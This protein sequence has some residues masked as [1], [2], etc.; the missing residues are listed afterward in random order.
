MLKTTSQICVSLNR[1]ISGLNDEKKSYG[2]QAAQFARWDAATKPVSNHLRFSDEHGDACFVPTDGPCY[3]GF[4]PGTILQPGIRLDCRTASQI[5]SKCYIRGSSTN[6]SNQGKIFPSDQFDPC[7]IDHLDQLDPA[8][9]Q[10]N[11]NYKRAL[12]KLLPP[13]TSAST[14]KS[15]STSQYVPIPWN[16]PPVSG[17]SWTLKGDVK[18]RFDISSKES[19]SCKLAIECRVAQLARAL[20]LVKMVH[21]TLNFLHKSDLNQECGKL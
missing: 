15:A 3:T 5:E 6:G 1:I 16:V 19:Q 20:S 18:T 12:K 7:N 4:E 11:D 10:L 21:S 8:V 14:N 17:A 2:V 9:A 13:K